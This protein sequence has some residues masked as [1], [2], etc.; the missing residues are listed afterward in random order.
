MVSWVSVRRT[1]ETCSP[2]YQVR[3][4][5]GSGPK[6]EIAGLR[7]RAKSRLMY[8][9]QKALLFDDLVGTQQDRGRSGDPE[10]LGGLEIEHQLVTGRQQDR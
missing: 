2:T 10:C 3:F 4:T 9:S 1:M 7:V 5:P 6:A 8:R